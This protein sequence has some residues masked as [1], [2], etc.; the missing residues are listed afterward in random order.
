MHAGFYDSF[1]FV[2]LAVDLGDGPGC[3]PVA[4]RFDH[5][6]LFFTS[7]VF[8]VNFTCVVGSDGTLVLDAEMTL[9]RKS[10]GGDHIAAVG[11]DVDAMGG[12]ITRIPLGILP[13][14]MG[15][16]WSRTGAPI[17]G[18]ILFLIT[19]ALF[20]TFMTYECM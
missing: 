11:A 1:L 7:F 16:T 8:S 18:N 12:G 2:G 17:G 15:E 5:I 19:T 20:C 6:F 14:K 4:A 9:M 3:T 13:R 10:D